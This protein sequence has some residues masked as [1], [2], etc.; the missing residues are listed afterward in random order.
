MK[1]VLLSALFLCFVLIGLF[2][3]FQLIYTPESVIDS[4]KN[5]VDFI[6]SFTHP[7]ES[8]LTM[9]IGK[10]EAGEIKGLKEFYSIHKEKKQDLLPALKKSEFESSESKG[11]AY[12]FTL[13][14]DTGFRG[15]GDW[16]LVA[17]PHPYYEASEEGYIQQITKVFINKA[18]LDT[19]W[20]NRVAEGYP[21]IM[22]LVKPYEVW[23]GGV[24]RGVVLDSDGNPVP[25]AEI[26]F[27]NMNYD[28]DMQNKK[29]TGEGKLKKSGAGIFLADAEGYFEFIP[30]CAGYWGFAAL[31]AG[32]QKEYEGKELSQDAVIWIEVL[33]LNDAKEQEEEQPIVEKTGEKQDKQIERKSD[34]SPAALIIVILLFVVM[35]AWPP[36]FKKISDKADNKQ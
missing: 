15:G 2:A 20:K 16:V 35:F 33:A 28:V 7:F 36:I 14:K 27:E 25:Y 4:S 30:P 3:H 26:E 31:G 1:K 34:F 17:V 19:D 21:E 29:F 13:D 24:F 6:L 8:G 32:K 18:G 12:D 11:F 10:N 5:S 23:E 22:P 9:D